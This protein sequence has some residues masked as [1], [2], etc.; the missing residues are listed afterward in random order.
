MTRLVVQV[1]TP[2][3][4]V[5]DAGEPASALYTGGMATP[6]ST[7]NPLFLGRWFQ[8]QVII[9]AVGWY[10]T[11]PLR[12]RQVGDLL[13]DPGGVGGC[14]HGSC[15]GFCAMRRSSEALAEV[16][17]AGGSELASR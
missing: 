7:R 15:V 13:R 8:D 14:E 1:G 12:Y 5:A 16:R 3:G 2:H 6:R 10:L 17:E 9:V 11:Y 4:S